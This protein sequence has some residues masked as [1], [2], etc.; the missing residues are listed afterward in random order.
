M[1]RVLNTPISKVLT[2]IFF[3]AQVLSFFTRLNDCEAV[4]A[5][6]PVVKKALTSGYNA[7]SQMKNMAI[8]NSSRDEF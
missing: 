3:K 5:R 6:L 2:S 4:I 1:V 8:L 7:I